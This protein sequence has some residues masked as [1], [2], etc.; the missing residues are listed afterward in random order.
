VWAHSHGVYNAPEAWAKALQ[1]AV[2]ALGMAM[3]FAPNETVNDVMARL[4]AW[5]DAAV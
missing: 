4:A 1:R 2:H 3:V 5:L